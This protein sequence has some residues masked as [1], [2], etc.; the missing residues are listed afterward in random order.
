MQAAAISAVCMTIRL[1]TVN[2]LFGF[3]LIAW[4]LLDSM[5]VHAKLFKTDRDLNSING[6]S[7]KAKYN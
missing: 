5:I 7:L 4:I 6:I 3:C 1:A 2:G